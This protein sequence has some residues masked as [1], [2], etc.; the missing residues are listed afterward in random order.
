MHKNRITQEYYT[1]IDLLFQ[2]KCTIIIGHILH[3]RGASDVE[4]VGSKYLSK[5]WWI[6]VRIPAKLIL[7]ICIAY[8]LATLT[9]NYYTIFKKYVWLEGPSNF[10]TIVF[11]FVSIAVCSL[12]W[13][14]TLWQIN[15]TDLKY[16][17]VTRRYHRVT[18]FV[19]EHDMPLDLL[20][21]LPPAYPV[22]KE[23]LKMSILYCVAIAFNIFTIYSTLFM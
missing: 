7:I 22:K 19:K 23:R 6:R 18:E 16:K 8:L 1:I 17:V 20:P 10:I 12:W 14:Q 5:W 11:S 9:L 2:V 15:L 3:Q 4:K 21:P 13:F